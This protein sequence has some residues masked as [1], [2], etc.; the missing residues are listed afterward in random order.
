MYLLVQ[1]LILP[2]YHVCV[3]GSALLPTLSVAFTSNVYLLPSSNITFEISN[4]Q[5]K[6]SLITLV[7]FHYMKKSERC[8]QLVY[9]Y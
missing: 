4:L 2:V 6:I 8:L 9:I 5:L 3:D 1:E 7:V